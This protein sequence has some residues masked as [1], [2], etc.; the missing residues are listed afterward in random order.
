MD[1]HTG[2]IALMLRACILTYEQSE[3]R[4]QTAKKA[5]IATCAIA[6][7]A[8]DSAYD[9]YNKLKSVETLIQKEVGVIWDK[10]QV[11]WIKNMDWIVTKSAFP[12]LKQTI[13][14]GRLSLK[15][16]QNGLTSTAEIWTNS[17]GL[18]PR[19]WKAAWTE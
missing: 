16:Q 4:L 8:C 17:K 5:M 12:D 7:P 9:A 15:F 2:K 14:A 10:Q 13:Q 6:P 19:D 3:F 1:Q 11:E 18:T